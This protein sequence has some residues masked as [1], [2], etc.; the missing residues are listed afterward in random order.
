[1]RR[2][3]LSFGVLQKAGFVA[4]CHAWTANMS[5][6]TGGMLARMETQTT[7]FHANECHFGVVE[8]PGED[9]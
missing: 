5:G 4:L 3:H 8:K 9:T 2:L 6:E 7:G 1:M